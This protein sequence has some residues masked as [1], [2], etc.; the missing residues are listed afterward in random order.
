MSGKQNLELSL[1]R[2]A[3]PERVFEDALFVGVTEERI[4]IRLWR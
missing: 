4:I 3:L 2:K 1:V